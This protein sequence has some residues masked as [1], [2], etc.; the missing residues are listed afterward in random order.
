[1]PNW[2]QNRV[3]ITHSDPI[4]S[5]KLK[6]IDGENF[7][8]TLYPL[9]DE[10]L[11]PGESNDLHIRLW[12]TKWDVTAYITKISENGITVEFSS[13][14]TPPIAFY[15]FLVKM[16]Y[17]VNAKYFECGIGYAGIY[18]DGEDTEFDTTTPEYHQMSTEFDDAF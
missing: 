14:W 11:H 17:S 3:T 1:M 15:D 10:N 5:S 6:K 7:F 2:C 13:A 12:G 9:D 4:L 8:G 18:N 16:G